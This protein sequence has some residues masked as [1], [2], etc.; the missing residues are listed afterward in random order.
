MSTLTRPTLLKFLLLAVVWGTSY[1]FIKA[2]LEGL[3]PGQ[4]VL[5]RLGFGLAFLAVA[6]AMFRSR[7]PADRK[8][9]GHLAVSSL[10]G[11]VIPFSL[12]AYGEERTSAAMAG[13]LIAVLPLAT[14]AGVTLLLPNERVSRRKVIGFLVGFVGVTVIAAPWTGRPGELL[15]Q[16]AVVGAAVSYAT[17]TVYIRRYLVP[18]GFAPIVMATTQVITALMIQSVLT[19]KLAWTT[20]QITPQVAMSVVILGIFATGVAYILY[21]NLIQELGAATASS[22][23]YLVPVVGAV[24]STTIL[25]D[26]ITLHMVLGV[27]M[28][29]AGLAMAEGRFL[30]ARKAV[31]RTEKPAQSSERDAAVVSGTKGGSNA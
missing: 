27:G 26:R 16:L 31:Q 21:N 3:S 14:L 1:T 19:P 20:P 18:Y 30:G 24:A 22:V 4:V 7:L 2:A 5:G 8:A 17:Q 12:L 23:N 15:G 11:M 25:G 10:F 29:L 28:V 9:W 6:G 13:M